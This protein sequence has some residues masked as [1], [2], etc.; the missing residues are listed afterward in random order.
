MLGTV[1]EVA[2]F[3][4]FAA[5]RQ[6]SA[7]L[8]LLSP[9][10]MTQ[11]LGEW[12]WNAGS[13]LIPA[14]ALIFVMASEIGWIS[15]ALSVRPLILGGEISYS[16]YLLHWPLLRSDLQNLPAVAALPKW[17]VLAVTL[18]VLL[19]LSYLVWAYIERPARKYILGL[20]SRH[21]LA[22]AWAISSKRLSLQVVTFAPTE[23]IAPEMIF[24]AMPQTFANEIARKPA[25]KAARVV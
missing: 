25:K 14:C 22:T 4:L 1:I 10:P 6:A 15:K 19:T 2:A 20:A 5:H 23:S 24:P 7:L 21:R 8:G 16:I 17:V 9:I 11:A 18:G 3:G 12:Y 13:T